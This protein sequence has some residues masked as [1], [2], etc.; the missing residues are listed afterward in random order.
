MLSN[1]NAI[2]GGAGVA[3]AYSTKDLMNFRTGASPYTNPDYSWVDVLI[4]DHSSLSRNI[5]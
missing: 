3:A 4:R 1:V 5:T 2:T